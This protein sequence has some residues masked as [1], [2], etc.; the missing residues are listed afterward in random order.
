MDI[1]LLGR[2]V[3]MTQIYDPS[4]NVIPVTVIQAGPCHVLQLKTEDRDGY[5][6]V[7]LGYL[8]KP[9][10]PRG[11]KRMTRRVASRSERG[12]VVKLDSNRPKARKAAGLP[13]GAGRRAPAPT[14]PDGTALR[15]AAAATSPGLASLLELCAELS[16]RRRTRSR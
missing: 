7:Q 1:G 3:G 2:K 4:G 10:P 16:G 6:A 5:E 14:G 15:P 13:A 11:R 8:D 9:R 12:H